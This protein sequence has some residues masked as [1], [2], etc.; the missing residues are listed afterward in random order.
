[1][2]FTP[3]VLPY[4]LVFSFIEPPALEPA[5]PWERLGISRSCYFARRK[6]RRAVDAAYELCRRRQPATPSAPTSAKIIRLFQPTNAEARELEAI[7]RRIERHC[8]SHRR[9][10]KRPGRCYGG[11]P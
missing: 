9:P 7:A 6:L 1:M 8:P 5:T 10:E 4:Q 2:N 3:P 11:K